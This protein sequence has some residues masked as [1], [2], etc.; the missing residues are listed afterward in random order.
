MRISIFGLGYVGAVS[1][2]CLSSEG[3]HV[4]GVD[5]N[6]TKIDLINVGRTPI[7]ED[8]VDVLIENAHKQGLLAAT[9][10]AAKALRGRDLS[11]LCVGIPSENNGNLNLAYVRNVCRGIREARRTKRA[12]TLS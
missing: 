7:I 3:H 8:Y 10:D 12:T 9:S 5:N 4:L 1:A 6:Q 11:V 2:A